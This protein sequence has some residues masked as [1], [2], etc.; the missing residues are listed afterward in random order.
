MAMTTAPAHRYEIHRPTIHVDM[1]LGWTQLNW[2]ELCIYK[3][4]RLFAVRSGIRI[5]VSVVQLWIFQSPISIFPP[6]VRTEDLPIKRRTH[7]LSNSHSNGIMNICSCC[8]WTIF[9]FHA[10]TEPGTWAFFQLNRHRAAFWAPTRNMASAI[11]KNH[12]LFK[13]IFKKFLHCPWSAFG[14][15]VAVRCG[16]EFHSFFCFLFFN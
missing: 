8:P 12:T 15:F 7:T 1:Y 11:F 16:F 3:F 13:Y 14:G 6:H 9:V 4:V 10:S 2:T 5:C